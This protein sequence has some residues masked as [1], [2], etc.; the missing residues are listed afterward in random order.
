MSTIKV[1]DSRQPAPS[2]REFQTGADRHFDFP[3]MGDFA[4]PY[5]FFSCRLTGEVCQVS[6]SFR[7]V[8]G[9]DSNAIIGITFNRILF[10]NCPLNRDE[11]DCRRLDLRNGKSVHVLRS[12]RNRE[13]RR[14][15]LS[16]QTIGICETTDAPEIR[17][18]NIALDITESVETYARAL[19]KFQRLAHAESRLTDQE[20]QVADRILQGAMNREIAAEL[21]ISER[22]V[23]RRRAMVMK[24][25][26]VSTTSEMVSHLVEKSVLQASIESLRDA[27]WRNARNASQIVDAASVWWHMESPMVRAS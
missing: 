22:T 2:M 11:P 13:G 10:P 5:F 19:A 9:Y 18:H 4:K 24:Q 20:R 14:R 17:R 16:I 21:E 25:L 3:R 7:E 26:K 8:L 1:Q 27:H 23:D 15:V 6:E 12:V